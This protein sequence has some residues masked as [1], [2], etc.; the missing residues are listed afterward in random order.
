M[1]KF[2]ISQIQNP[3]LKRIISLGESIT[4]RGEVQEVIR[5]NWRDI[6]I[7][8]GC[9]LSADDISVKYG[10]SRRS[11]FYYLRMLG[12]SIE[13][14]RRLWREEEEMRKRTKLE[15]LQMRMIRMKII[16]RSLQEFEQQIEWARR[17]KANISEQTY[18]KYVKVWIELQE[19]CGKHIDD[20]TKDDI[21]E[22]L[23]HKKLEL[24]EKG[25]N[26]QDRV[27]KAQ[28]SSEIITPLRVLC[29]LKGIPLDR[30]LRTSE[31]ESPYK[32]VRIDVVERF[33]I[34]E[35]IHERYP[36]DFEWIKSVLF[37]LYYNGHRARELTT[38]MF[39]PQNGIVICYSK[40]KRGLRY[41]KILRKDVY[42][43]IKGYLPISHGQL[44]K[45]QKILK[46]AYEKVLKDGTV[47][48]E[49]ALRHQI[50]VWRHTSCND[51]IEYSDYNLS[52]IMET[53][54]WRNPSMIVKIYGKASPDMIA[55][56]LR[57]KA[58]LRRP[59]EF[60]HNV[61]SVERRKDKVVIKKTRALLD[62]AYGRGW[63][64]KEY[65]ETVR[66]IEQ[67]IIEEFKAKHG[68]KVEVVE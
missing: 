2:K 23:T 38:L 8:I 44:R 61:Y 46:E 22:Y 36:K 39:E 64:S 16:P 51:L 15:K 30:E 58:E 56:A 19:F 43:M 52:L 31:Y 67:M 49:Y 26:L 25:K 57:W 68:G 14:I 13:E 55:R 29:Q 27:V 1:P 6:V 3:K 11:L 4:T 12:T 63:I 65:Y 5:K 18:K 40:G 21:L 24:Q 48:K 9:G 62:E 20:I 59:F 33:K 37:S 41:E 53:L 34:L 7:D 35:F 66:N 42:E 47:T 17:L 45:L 60:I 28:F 50:H 54:G 10:I 32:R